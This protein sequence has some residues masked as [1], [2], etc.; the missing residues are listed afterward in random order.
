MAN[1]EKRG[2]YQWRALVRRKGYKPVSR[3][4]PTK[5]E[6]Q[7]WARDI[8]AQMR[9]R[10]FVDTSEAERTTLEESLSRYLREVTPNK[11]GEVQE[12]RRV[13]AWQRDPLAKRFVTDVTAA[14]IAAWRDARLKAGA[15]PTT[16]R[17]DLALIS[18][19]YTTARKEWGWPISN[20][21]AD[22]RLPRQAE[23]RKR[24]LEPLGDGMTEEAWLLLGA[25]GGPDWLV[26]LIRLALETAAR[27]GELLALRWADVN[28]KAGTARFNETKAGGARTI[29]LSD[30]ALTVLAEWRGDISRVGKVFPGVTQNR[31]SV[32]FARACE[33]VGLDDLRY[34]DL[35]HEGVSRLFEAG[36]N[37]MEVASISG[38]RTMQM[39]MRYTHPRAADLAEKLNRTRPKK[40][41]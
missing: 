31:V 12:R 1:I 2:Q 39:L 32:L 27:Q 37:H 3:T 4:F 36:L 26:P 9:R 13:K 35:R 38:H 10:V 30:I 8:E 24:R 34:H 33:S 15:S 21:V 25:A 17:T 28:E 7:D 40:S 22:V 23:G 16:C 29:P 5:G 14:D 41:E 11:K 19:L 20:P 6:A 18:H